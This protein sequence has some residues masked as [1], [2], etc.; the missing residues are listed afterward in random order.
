MSPK[1]A[2]TRLDVTCSGAEVIECIVDD[3]TR[4]SGVTTL[5]QKILFGD[6][7]ITPEGKTIDLK[8][9]KGVTAKQENPGKF[10][11]ESVDKQQL[12]QVCADIQKIRP[13]EPYKLKGI[14]LEGQY[15]RKKVR[16]TAGV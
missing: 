3:Y 7:C 2:S 10:V 11:L 13:V 12:G 5:R 8:L 6:H 15:L 4:V 14:R 9:P 16:K 1:T